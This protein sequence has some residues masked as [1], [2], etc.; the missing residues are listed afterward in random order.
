M[1]CFVAVDFPL[2]VK[3][4]INDFILKIGD[5][6]GDVKWVPSENMHL[7][8]KFLGEVKDEAVGNVKQ[9]L[10]SV[11]AGHKPF[12]IYIKGAGA[13][14]NFKSPNVLW[15]GIGASPEL[16]GLFRDIDDT[17]AGLGFVR[18]TRR[19]SPHLTIARVKDKRS[20]GPMMKGLSEF[21]EMSFGS[22]EVKEF[23]LMK[24]VL[25]PSGAEYSRVEAFVLGS[26]IG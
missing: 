14:P 5:L 10:S 18:E 8:L 19:F 20:I 17:A 3:R 1:R 9:G 21:R 13:F 4:A 22:A 16:A 25:K 26:S 7:T 2:D 15:V 24:S 11:C 12:S 23:L 6:S